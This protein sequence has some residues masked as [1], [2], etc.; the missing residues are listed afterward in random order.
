MAKAQPEPDP[1]KAAL[2]EAQELLAIALPVPS[3][4]DMVM[5]GKIAARDCLA[6]LR[7]VLTAEER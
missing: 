6:K 2:G 1:V 4:D 3:N 7:E 5:I